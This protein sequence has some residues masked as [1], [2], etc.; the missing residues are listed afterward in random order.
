MG[1][2]QRAIQA[3]RPKT[4]LK[5]AYSEYFSS[6]IAL[7]LELYCQYFYTVSYEPEVNYIF[8]LHYITARLLASFLQSHAH[9]FRPH[10]AQPPAC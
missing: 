4:V 7:P 6:C 8:T 3:T 5:I 10:K 1:L 2:H 9:I